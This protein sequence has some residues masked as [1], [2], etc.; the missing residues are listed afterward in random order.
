MAL[1]LDVPVSVGLDGFIIEVATPPTAFNIDEDALVNN[2]EGGGGASMECEVSGPVPD[3]VARLRSAELFTIDFLDDDL[4]DNICPLA[5]LKVEVTVLDILLED[6]IA[7]LEDF[8]TVDCM[9]RI[10]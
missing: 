7:L 4:D 8:G 1:V 6:D 10:V 5:L 3:A 9:Y 2:D